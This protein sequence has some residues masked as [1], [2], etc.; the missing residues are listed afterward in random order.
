VVEAVEVGRI[1]V[2]DAASL[3][4]C[5][6]AD[7]NRII[8]Q[9]LSGEAR[10]IGQARRNPDD[11][12]PTPMW[13]T[14]ALLQ[15]H[16]PETPVVVEPSA[17]DGSI[18]SVLARHG[19]EV[20][21]IERR[22]TCGKALELAGATRVTIGD[23]L[24]MLPIPTD[25]GIV[26]NPPFGSDLG[27]SFVKAC[28]ATGAPYVAMLLQ[29]DFFSSRPRAEWNNNHPVAGF[30]PLGDRPSFTADGR[31]DGR[32]YA[33]FVWQRDRALRRPLVLLDPTRR[34]GL[35]REGS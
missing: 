13:V 29:L 27:F 22:P 1:A 26:G 16:P 7:Q 17:G 24:E 33:W 35:G 19:Y 4:S 8:G 3:A 11:Y 14:E 6:E 10:T 15:V 34:Q 12:Y 32:N 21:A 31:T 25:E 20:H 28:V 23:A 9:I 2:S 5:S 18:V 30:Y